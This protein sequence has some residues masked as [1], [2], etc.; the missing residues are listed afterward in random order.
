MLIWT[1]FPAGGYQNLV[2]FN[3]SKTQLSGLVERVFSV[4][5]VDLLEG[6]QGDKDKSGMCSLAMNIHDHLGQQHI[7]FIHA[8]QFRPF[9]PQVADELLN[10][11][12]KLLHIFPGHNG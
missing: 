12:N 2:K 7:T 3:A 9:A 11:D 4:N 8:L 5:R 10:F 6:K 1:A